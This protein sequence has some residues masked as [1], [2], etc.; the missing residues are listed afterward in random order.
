MSAI[1]TREGQ[2]HELAYAKAK[3]LKDDL[4]GTSCK[5]RFYFKEVPSAALQLLF[6]LRVSS[7]PNYELLPFDEYN[8]ASYP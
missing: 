4:D 1:L 3:I 2:E 6:P 8:Q 7:Q 5:M